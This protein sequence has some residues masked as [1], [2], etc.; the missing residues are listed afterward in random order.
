MDQRRSVIQQIYVINLDRQVDRWN[1]IQREL[2]RIYS[3]SKTPLSEIAKRFS[4]VDARY[5]TDSPSHL[6]LQTY[7][8]LADQLFV[9]PDPLLETDETTSN[10]HVA[11]TRQEIAVALSHIAVWKLIASSDHPYTLVLEDDVYFRRDFPQILD[12]VWAG[13]TRSYEPFD[14]FDILYLSYK[15]AKTK[16][17]KHEVSDFLFKPL[18]GLWQLSGYVLSKK[19]AKNLLGLLPVR[20]PVDLWINY[21]FDKLDVFATH[22]SI[23]D[24]RL[25]CRSDNSYSILPVLAR[26]GVL[27]QEKPLLFKTRPL[28][29]P[30]FAIGRQGTGLT[31]LAMALSMLGYRCCSDI[32][33]LPKSEHDDL[34]ANKKSRVFDAYVNVGSLSG[35]HCIKLAKLYRRAKFIITIGDE[36][37]LIELN[38]ECA[39]GEV[40]RRHYRT[41][42]DDSFR[43]LFMLLRQLSANILVLPMKKRGKWEL[44]CKFLECEHPSSQYPAFE[45][46]EQCHLSVRSTE[47]KRS[48]FPRLSKMKFDSSPWIVA[49][50]RKWHGIPISEVNGD[51]FWE[52]NTNTISERFQ[53]FD[54]SLWILL[55]DTFPSNLA[56]FSP[57]NFS[58]AKDHHARLTLRKECA[59][60]REYTSA[61][62]CSR[63]S[64][65]YGRFS[66]KIRPANLQGLVTGVFLYRNSPRQ[67]IDI[68]FLGKDA[69]KLL[70][71][72]YYNP[73]GEGANLEY[74]YRGTP[75]LIDLGFDASKDFHLYAIQ[76]SPMSIRWLVDGRL[77]YER[78]NWDPTPIPH[79]PMKFYV[80]LWHSRSE[81]L[82]GRLSERDLP[83]HS[84][85]RSIDIQ[86]FNTLDSLL[87]N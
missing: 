41:D 35:Q 82:A 60:V 68:E 38:K 44:L 51:D 26:V 56:I 84:E 2:Q 73:G 31:S 67:E 77:V 76:W 19:G 13:L 50:R 70:V 37:E 4:A 9:E 28:P 21:Q 48:V 59:R 14:A 78:A 49:P 55:N 18:R 64:Y 46:Q 81:E 39:N 6:D 36:E 71:N 42:E 3:G 11:M 75:L 83:T 86:Y 54:S 16:V 30:V 7:Y 43:A 32:N 8:S 40:S 5:Y 23:I 79:L 74:G 72:V 65:L 80:N 85:I 17:E 61:S 57:S 27:T 62:I 34:F 58:I 24:Q 66:V 22:R 47:N 12:K 20:G 10:G 69:T 53:S 45:D 1:Q 52:N 87:E 33:E 63:R 25:D 29:K 15:E